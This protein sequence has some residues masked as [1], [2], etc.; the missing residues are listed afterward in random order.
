MVAALKSP[1]FQEI[2]RIGAH[3]FELV[4]E[5]AKVSQVEADALMDAAAQH[6]R[7]AAPLAM[8][9]EHA[10]LTG[11]KVPLGDDRWYGFTVVGESVVL[12]VNDGTRDAALT[13]TPAQTEGLARDALSVK[14]GAAKAAGR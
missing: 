12:V 13:L 3:F 1:A 14:A 10:P 5:H 2:A 9:K 6:I 7:S 4:K 11:V 8:L